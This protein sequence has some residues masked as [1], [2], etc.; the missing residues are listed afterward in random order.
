MAHFTFSIQTCIH[1]IGWTAVLIFDDY[2]TWKIRQFGLAFHTR[3]GNARVTP[4]ESWLNVPTLWSSGLRC[5]QL[6]FLNKWNH[7]DS[8]TFEGGVLTGANHIPSWIRLH[9]I[10]VHSAAR[11]VHGHNSPFV[12]DF[13][14]INRNEIWITVHNVQCAYWREFSRLLMPTCRL[15]DW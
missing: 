10:P 12:S 6:S 13:G 15:S 2:R 5:V 11:L 8:L 4:L 14:L 1:Y 3:G 7:L 9:L